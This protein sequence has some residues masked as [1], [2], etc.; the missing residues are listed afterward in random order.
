MGDI[1]NIFTGFSKDSSVS[2]DIKDIEQQAAVDNIKEFLDNCWK[3]L[4]WS[5]CKMYCSSN[6]TFRSQALTFH[7]P[8]ASEPDLGSSL[9]NY[10]DWMG[11]IVEDVLSNCYHTDVKLLYDPKTTTAICYCMFHGTHSKTPN[12]S[13]LPSPTMKDVASDCSYKITLDKEGKIS[14]MAK[15]WNS[16]WFE[17]ELG[18]KN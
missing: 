5:W 15:V 1:P 8:Q 9:K 18:W 11:I 7:P 12:G 10:V 3:G 6:A 4:G 13:N 2:S 14:D 17:K 16:E